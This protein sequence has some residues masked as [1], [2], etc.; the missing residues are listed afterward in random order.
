[1]IEKKKKLN[2]KRWTAHVHDDRAQNN[3][4]WM[5]YWIIDMVEKICRKWLNEM[6]ERIGNNGTKNVYK[7]MG[8]EMIK[9]C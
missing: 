6:I 1:M 8:M 3:A 9:S 2:E 5:D 7:G 4:R